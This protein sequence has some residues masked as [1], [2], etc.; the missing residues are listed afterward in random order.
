M[1]NCPLELWNSEGFNKVESAIKVSLFVDKINGRYRKRTNHARLCAEV[2]V[3]FS[4]CYSG[5]GVTRVQN[6][7]SDSLLNI[8][9]AFLD[10]GLKSDTVQ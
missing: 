1:K 6:Q 9:L 8:I 10:V 7:V 3:S 5:T 2:D 4:L